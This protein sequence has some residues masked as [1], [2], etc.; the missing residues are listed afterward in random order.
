VR[1]LL[2]TDPLLWWLADDPEL[3]M[4]GQ[5]AIADPANDVAISV[6]TIWEVEALRAQGRLE[7]PPEWLDLVAEPDFRTLT[8][9]LEHAALAA[10][11]PPHHEDPCDRFLI[12]QAVLEGYAIV[13]RDP[14]FGRYAVPTMLA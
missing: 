5:A 4:M 2:D 7:M 12:A 11:L 6:A 1:L 10:A 3:G 8:L 13:T 14:P 9:T